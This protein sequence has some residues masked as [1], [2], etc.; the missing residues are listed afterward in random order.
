MS[1]QGI[2]ELIKLHPIGNG[3]D[4]FRNF[5]KSTC[6]GAGSPDE[7]DQLGRDGKAAKV[8]IR[9]CPLSRL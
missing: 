8:E 4:L 3:L 1:D 9:E 6:A 7:I 2:S 5:L